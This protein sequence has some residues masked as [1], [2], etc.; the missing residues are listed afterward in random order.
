MSE[1]KNKEEKVEKNLAETPELDEKA[2]AEAMKPAPGTEAISS[3]DI[4]LPRLRLL[5]DTSAEVKAQ[6]SKAGRLK[7]SLTEEILDEVQFIPISM[8]KSRLMFDPDNR[9]GAP[10]CRSV[11]TKVGS[12]GSKCSE[13]NNAQWREGR[14]P[15]CNVIFNYLIITPDEIGKMIMPTI[16][17]LMKTS[18]QA[19]LKLNT[20]VEFT[21][22]RQ[23]FWNR[24]WLLAPKQKHF[25]KGPA[26]LLNVTQIR[27][28]NEK[29]R[30]WCE[31][32]YKNTIGK[33]IID[34]EEQPAADMSA[35]DLN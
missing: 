35:D 18:A 10:L 4:V 27:E 17:S 11:D 20:S 16:L 33:K 7:H 25:P 2:L 6:E 1:K 8:Y 14:P 30:R 32:I 26:Y 15:V 34:A 9:E 31:L 28:T 3:E 22:P 23:P 21:I 12:D 24:V 29:E 19:A 5:Q 13:C